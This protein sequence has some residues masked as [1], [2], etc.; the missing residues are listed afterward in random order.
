MMPPY[1]ES[2]FIRVHHPR[3]AK[4]NWLRRTLLLPKPGD[5][6][7]DVWVMLFD[8][9][10][11]ANCAIKV[12]HPSP[13]RPTGKTQARHPLA[14]FDGT[15]KLEVVTARAALGPLRLPGRRF[16]GAR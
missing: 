11:G 2:R 13:V 5:T 4:A 6:V 8:P 10:G 1:Y 12:L 3:R 16:R 15:V 9:D 14:R 7:A